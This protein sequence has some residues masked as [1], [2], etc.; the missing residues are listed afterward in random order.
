MVEG[1]CHL[2]SFVFIIVWSVVGIRCYNNGL[3]TTLDPDFV[4]AH[5]VFLCA[6][7]REAY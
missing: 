7:A 2:S 5:T 1:S 4:E 3:V 6:A